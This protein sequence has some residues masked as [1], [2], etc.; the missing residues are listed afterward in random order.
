M[1]MQSTITHISTSAFP[2]QSQVIS[3]SYSADRWMYIST[4]PNDLREHANMFVHS[5]GV[6]VAMCLQ[7][8]DTCETTTGRDILGC[9]RRVEPRASWKMDKRSSLG[10]VSI[11][12]TREVD[13]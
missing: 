12:A 5:A 9:I 13:C 1:S 10:T 6:C 8:L 11:G 7:R 4:R 2:L 3:N